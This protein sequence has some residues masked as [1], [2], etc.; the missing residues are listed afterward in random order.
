MQVDAS[1]NA[2]KLEDAIKLC[3]ARDEPWRGSTGLYCRGLFQVLTGLFQVSRDFRGSGAKQ[4]NETR[5]QSNRSTRSNTETT[6]KKRMICS[7]S[8]T[9]WVFLNTIV[10]VATFIIRPAF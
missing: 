10:I 3:K 6:E 5:M 2:F 8:N 9:L 7:A 1:G 4:C